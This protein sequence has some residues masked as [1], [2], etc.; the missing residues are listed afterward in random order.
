MDLQMPVMGG[1]EAT[2][3][4]RREEQGR[5]VPIIAMT[6]SAM[7]TDR[8]ACLAAGMDDY[9]SK[10]L[11]HNALREMLERIAQAPA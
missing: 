9:I 10:P 8:E 2:E 7:A 1:I 5:R 4:W 6:A 3:I 11:N